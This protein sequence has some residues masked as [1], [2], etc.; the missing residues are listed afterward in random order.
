MVGDFLPTDMDGKLT[1][2]TA[3]SLGR[4]LDAVGQNRAKPFFF[5]DFF[6]Q[7]DNSRRVAPAQFDP[8]GLP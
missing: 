5:D 8:L 4:L 1:G 3:D 6:K 7:R 2:L